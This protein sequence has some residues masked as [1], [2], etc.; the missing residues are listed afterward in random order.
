MKIALIGY[1]KMG[2]MIEQIAQQQGHT[3]VAKLSPRKEPI[4]REAISTADVCID[5]S[6]PSCIV[7]NIRIISSVGKNIVVGTTGWDESMEEVKRLVAQQGIGLIYSPN[8]SIGVAL[9]F[10][11]VSQAAA[12]INSQTNYEAGIT[13]E[14]HQ[15]KVDS[16]SGTALALARLVQEN[17]RKK[18]LPI[19]SLR[20]GFIPGTHSVYFDSPHDTITLTH[21]ARNRQGFAQGAVVAAEWL[22]GKK[23]F[24]TLDDMLRSL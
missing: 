16:P 23:G 6:H 15:Q 1:G 19:S 8:F 10:E 24:F 7:Q 18:N 13:E 14:H 22:T 2:Q 5:F 4:T 21:Q 3:I 12:L 9:F 17:W 20:C 11:I